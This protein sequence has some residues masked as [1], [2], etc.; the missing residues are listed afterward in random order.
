MGLAEHEHRKHEGTG[1]GLGSTGQYD[2]TT[3]TGQ[4]HHLGRDAAVGAGG[5]EV[6]EHEH[7]KHEGLTGSNQGYGN[8]TSSGLTGSNQGYDNTTSSGLTGSN[9]GQHH[10]GR[11]AAG[12]GAAGAVGEHEY[13]KHD[14]TS[15]QHSGLT[16]GSGMGMGNTT[17]A[18]GPNQPMVGDDRN[19]L[20]KDP[21]AD[22]PAAQTQQGMG[23]GMGGGAH[24][25]GSSGERERLVGQGEQS[26]DGQTGVEN[27]HAAGGVNAASNY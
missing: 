5:V 21:P 20:H 27:S 24:V 16:G 3:G 25:P 13:R 4:Q 17:S 26:L 1:S 12:L 18:T 7:R 9:Q 22:H 11:D 23:V 15:G 19:R 10:Y 2:N 8:T 14:I 6:A